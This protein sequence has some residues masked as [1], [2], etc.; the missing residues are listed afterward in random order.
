LMHYA[1][2]IEGVLNSGDVDIENLAYW[3]DT[4]QSE[5]KL[6][7][8]EITPIPGYISTYIVHIWDSH[9]VIFETNAGYQVHGLLSSLYFFRETGAD[10]QLADLTGDGVPELILDYTRSTCCT[11]FHTYKVY[12]L[13]VNPPKLLRFRSCSTNEMEWIVGNDESNLVPLIADT[14]FSGFI[15][16]DTPTDPVMHPCTVRRYSTYRWIGDV[17]EWTESSHEIKPPG[18]YDEK[19]ICEFARDISSD[20]EDTHIIIDALFEAEMTYDRVESYRPAVLFRLGE[21]HASKGDVDQARQYFQDVMTFVP[22]NTESISPWVQG[23]EVF[24]QDFHEAEEFYTVCKQVEICDSKEAMK[25]LGNV[26]SLQDIG[27]VIET[28]STH[29]VHIRGYGEYDFDGDGNP[30]IWITKQES[31]E[32]AYELWIIIHS[33]DR[34]SVLYVDNLQVAIPN[35]TAYSARYGQPIIQI[36]AE[37]LFQLNTFEFTGMPFI[38]LMQKKEFEETSEELQLRLLDKAVEGLFKGD[39]PAL[40]LEIFQET[41]MATDCSQDN[42]CDKLYYFSGLAHELMGEDNLAV[43]AYVAL[44]EQY[45]ESIYATMARMKLVPIHD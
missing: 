39:D 6:E 2:M 43:E 26:L 12:D 23:A 15:V 30:E 31:G 33:P 4:H 11:Y 22:K 3:F 42:W 32:P 34:S 17:F 14:G 29:G 16:E 35:F 13:T 38:T 25:Q 45:P 28:L 41:Q 19:E 8:E 37:T 44:W 36:D 5:L 20:P 40:S 21:Y 18:K 1:N 7:L 9:F 10:H 27:A 24:I